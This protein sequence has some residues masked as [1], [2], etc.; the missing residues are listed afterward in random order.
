MPIC[1]ECGL[2]FPNRVTIDGK[3][4]I[5][6]KR[7]YCFSCLPFGSGRKKY[8]IKQRST[9]DSN[10]PI[11]QRECVECKQVKDL[12]LFYNYNA[13]YKNTFRN[14]YMTICKECAKNF[15][16]DR[17]QNFKKHCLEYKG[18]KCSKCGYS[19]CSAALEFHHIDPSKKL[20]KLSDTRTRK[21]ENVK[22]ELD[23]CELLCSNCHKE[24]HHQELMSKKNN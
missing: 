16:K 21:W 11:G 19:K 5:I 3:L 22:E 10:I 6:N 1:R 18:G 13:K 15:S 2:S 17:I 23:K 9:Q 8:L 24:A 20:F 14:K 4:K 7:T 12:S